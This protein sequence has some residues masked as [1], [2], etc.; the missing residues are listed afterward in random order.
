MPHVKPYYPT[1]DEEIIRAGMRALALR[2]WS[3]ATA[4]EKAEQARKMVAGQRR[5]R[6]HLRA[7]AKGRAK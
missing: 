7:K 1:V 5:K 2:R 3:R 4:E 6:Q